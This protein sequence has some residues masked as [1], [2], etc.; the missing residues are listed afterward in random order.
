MR[1]AHEQGLLHQRDLNHF[2]HWALMYWVYLD[3]RTDNETRRDQLE[4]ECFNMFPDRWAEIYKDQ[5]G[6][7]LAPPEE[8]QEIPVDDIDEINR[9][10][11]S[12]ERSRIMTG[13]MD[14]PSPGGPE[15]G[16]WQ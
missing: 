16:E 15:W 6:S 9:W 7:L 1:L 13:A 2:Q 11:E 12:R 5:P 3:R 14:T 10:Y 4:L 8:S